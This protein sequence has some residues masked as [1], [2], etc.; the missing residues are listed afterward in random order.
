MISFDIGELELAEICFAVSGYSATRRL[1]A[2]TGSLVSCWCLVDCSPRLCFSITAA[3]L[4]KS[5]IFTCRFLTCLFWHI[6]HS[7]SLSVLALL[8]LFIHSFFSSLTKA[9]CFCDSVVL[10]CIANNLT[11]FTVRSGFPFKLTG[12]PYFFLTESKHRKVILSRKEIQIT[13]KTMLCLDDIFLF[14]FE[15]FSPMIP[16]LLRS[17]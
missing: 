16:R 10:R 15:A 1:A 8:Y 12:T 2:L 5:E 14:L 3:L 7:H 9:A 6:F 17:A 4:L 13:E 11:P